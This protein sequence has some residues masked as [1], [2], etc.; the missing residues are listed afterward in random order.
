MGEKTDV[1]MEAMSNQ[2]SW[3]TDLG[4]ALFVLLI[5]VIVLFVILL[6]GV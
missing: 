3:Q 1:E 2:G 6:G 5:V 4:C